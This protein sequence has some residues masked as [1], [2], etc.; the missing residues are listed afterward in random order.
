MVV[1][2]GLT[3]LACADALATAGHDVVVLEARP[4][5]GGRVLTVRDGFGGQH[6]EAGAE[7]VDADHA[8]VAALAARSGLA[9][10]PAGPG[11]GATLVDAGG[12]LAPVAAWDQVGEGRVSADLAAW[13]A[14]LD[15]LDALDPA[16]ADGR[17][18]G[19]LVDGLGLSAVG[20][21]LVGRRLRTV[22]GVPPEELSQLALVGRRRL[23][24]GPDA[25]RALRVRGGADGLAAALAARLPDG[26]LRLGV[27]VVA[28]D[29]TTVHTAAGA[30]ERAD[31]V[32]LA[33]PPP[34]LGRIAVRPDLPYEATAV[35]LGL[36]AAVHVQVARRLW[37]DVG[38]NGSVVSDRA[39]GQ[40]TEATATQAGDAGILTARL[41][42]NDG[43]ALAALPDLTARVVAEVERAFPGAGGLAG[44]T[45]VVD[46]SND[47]W[48]LGTLP[49]PTPGQ[50]TWIGDAVRRPH[51][52]VVLA[53]DHT[54][55]RHPGTMDGALRSGARAA[56]Q[57]LDLL[58]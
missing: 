26:A 27:E 49:V 54:D 55:D 15:A 25:E 9:L 44:A 7:L 16:V 41:S 57:V 38:R 51:G 10:E 6:A 24:G 37:R 52:R 14:A 48:S 17:H 13:D 45:A 19:T 53:G 42:S 28:V 58:G 43:A 33:V 1:G 8:E 32:V 20:R 40:L 2:A 47:P 23:R 35:G 46:W 56:A 5:V 31:A 18:A 22:F 36:G 29:G 50:L 12:R 11:P 30:E 21:L 34:V 4:R 39:H 3:G